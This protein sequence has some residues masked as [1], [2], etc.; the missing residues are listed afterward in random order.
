MM[1]ATKSPAKSAV[2]LE[3]IETQETDVALYLSLPSS[4]SERAVPGLEVRLPGRSGEWRSE[5]EGGRGSC[6]AAP[7][8][9]TTSAG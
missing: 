8:M 4:T 1:L 3:S 9:P 5:V 7:E 6:R 2:V